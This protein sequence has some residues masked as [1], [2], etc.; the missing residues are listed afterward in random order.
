MIQRIQSLWLVLAALAAFFTLKF[1]FFSGN[2]MD[3]S[4]I[5]T[6]QELTAI[7]NILILI[8][9][10]ALGVMAGI[11]IFLYKNRKL[12]LR[13]AFVA[14]A[15]S[16]ITLALY[17]FETKKFTEGNFNLT[18]LIALSMPVLL[19]LASRGIYKD[20]K[21]IKSADRLR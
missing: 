14:L 6:W 20:E 15:V 4:S 7:N 18:A 17:Y 2:K 12:Q 10:I 8:L 21:L 1:S 19:A 13:L 3:Q 11:C 9:T 5:K 16:L